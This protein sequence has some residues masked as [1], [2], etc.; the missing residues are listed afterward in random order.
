MKARVKS[1]IR[2]GLSILAGVAVGLAAVVAINNESLES[3][4]RVARHSANELMPPAPNLDDMVAEADAILIAEIDS[5]D[6]AG[7]YSGYSGG[8]LLLVLT[9]TPGSGLGTP[10]P[11]PLYAL[12]FIDLV[13]D[14]ESVIKDDASSEPWILRMAPADAP[15]STSSFCDDDAAEFPP[16]NISERYMFFL[17]QAPDGAY[18]LAHGPFD[19]IVLDNGNDEVSYSDCLKSDIPFAAGMDEE[20]FVDAVETQVAA[21]TRTP[22]ATSTPTRTPTATP[23]P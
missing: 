16:G 8:S 12:P 19:R 14:V 23:T 10:T 6:S 20:D 15:V 13:L 17:T 11:R 9:P 18:G 4:R 21:P 1:A 3:P 5:V 7:L 22:T 2:V